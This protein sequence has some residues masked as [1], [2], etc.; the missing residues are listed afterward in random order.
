MVVMRRLEEHVFHARRV[1]LAD[2]MTAVDLDLDARAVVVS[3]M[4]VNSPALAR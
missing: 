1:D 3:T 2:R 4:S